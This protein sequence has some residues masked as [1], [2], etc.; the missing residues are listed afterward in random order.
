MDEFLRLVEQA[1]SWLKN[2]ARRVIRGIMS[3]FIHIVGWFKGLGLNQAKDTP[4]IMNAK[5]PQFKQMLKNAPVKTVGVFDEPR[6]EVFKGVFD[7]ETDEIIHSELLGADA[8]DQQTQTILGN[9]P[10]VVLS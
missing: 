5:S 7:A 2:L 9:E 1:F 10:I 4:F 6:A 3:F 8:L